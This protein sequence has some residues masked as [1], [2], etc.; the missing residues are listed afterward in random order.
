MEPEQDRI[1]PESHRGGP[2]EAAVVEA[3]EVAL[4]VAHLAGFSRD[5]AEDVAP[6]VALRLLL[7]RSEVKCPGA[8]ARCVARSIVRDT[9]RRSRRTVPLDEAPERS[10]E[11]GLALELRLDLLRVLGGLDSRSRELVCGSLWGLSHAELAEELHLA[12]SGV[13]TLLRRARQAAK[14]SW[15]DLSTA[16]TAPSPG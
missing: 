1:A 15:N 4:L 9:L 3:A 10:E 8:W 6:E 16:A 5:D 14:A 2:G 12:A 11:P 7:V 13:G